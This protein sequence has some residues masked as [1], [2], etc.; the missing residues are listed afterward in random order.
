MAV[1]KVFKNDSVTEIEFTGKQKLEDLLTGKELMPDTPCGGTGKCGKCTVYIGND[2]VLACQ[3]FVEDSAEIYIPKHQAISK[4]RTEGNLPDFEI[5]KGVTGFGA[6]IDI[7]TTT[8]V[9]RL[10][11]LATGEMLPPVSQE[12]PQRMLAADVIGRIQACLEKDNLPLLNGMIRD[13]ISEMLAHVCRE[14]GVKREELKNIVITGNTTM[15]YLFSNRMPNTLA[16]SPFIADCLF[17]FKEEEFTY[18]PCYGAFVGGD[19]YTA[20][21][22]SGMTQDMN[23]TSLLIDLGTNGEIAMLH[24]GKLICCATACGPAFEGTG[25]INGGPASDGA[26]DHAWIKDGKIEVSTIGDVPATH[27]CGSGLMDIIACLLELEII[28]ETGAMDEEYELSNGVC[29]YPKDVRQVQL[30]KGAICA[31][32][33]TL[34]G[35]FGIKPADVDTLYIA[36]GFG[37][38]ITL[39]SAAAIGLFPEEMEN[40]AK[41]IGNAALTGAIMMLLG[42]DAQKNNR[43]DADCINLAEQPEFSDLFMESM[44]F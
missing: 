6:A 7:G 36:G 10:I 4:I 28:D 15:L 23:K 33:L 35:K 5:A 24:D 18:P 20:I 40:K 25:I 21:N 3:A 44:F 17:G 9:C 27:I 37:S 38:Y 34:I 1:L 2:K 41:V 32:I 13:T 43:L 8:V 22:A 12:N 29:L 16:F 19:I 30:A 39:S 11:D 14:A 42:N 31:G 26:I